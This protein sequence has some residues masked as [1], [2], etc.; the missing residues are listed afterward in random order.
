MII[1]FLQSLIQSIIEPFRFLE[2][3][4]VWPGLVEVAKFLGVHLISGMIPAFFIAGAIGVFLDKHRITKYMGAEANPLISY[5]MAALSGGILTVCSCGVLPIFTTIL[6]QGAGTGPAYTFLVASPAVNLISLSYTFTL[7]G[8][9]FTLGRAVLVF[10]A[11]IAIGLGMKLVFKE[12][13]SQK[14][15]QNLVVVEELDRTDSQLFVFFM[16]QILI[17]L[18]STGILDPLFAFLTPITGSDLLTRILA[19]FC[20]ILL[21]AFMSYKCF[22]LDEIKLWLKKAWSLMLMILPKVIAGIFFAGVIAELFPLT[23]FMDY[24]DSNTLTANFSLSFI[25]SMMYFG[26][27]V[28]ITFVSVF[29]GYG[30]H[31]GP[32]MALILSAPAVSL[33]S[34]LALAPLVGTKKTLVFLSLVV[35][36]S[37]LSGLFYGMIC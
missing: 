18:S 35:V 19:V 25:G 9:R 33:P 36:V 5:P 6:H 29:I 26:T 4:W 31:Q 10:F 28:G 3:T 11:S 20:E 34:L 21:L 22:Y 32:A 30:M 27:I 16:L 14:V 2:N 24:F 37:A 23:D 13:L 17:M 1:S 8:G 12:D 7:L 15:Q